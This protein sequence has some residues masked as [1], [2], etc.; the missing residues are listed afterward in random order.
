VVQEVGISALGFHKAAMKTIPIEVIDYSNRN[1]LPL[2]EIPEELPYHTIYEKYNRLVNQRENERLTKMYKLNEKLM[3][4]VLLEKDLNSIVKVIGE[5]INTMVC[6][7]DPY[8]DLIGY[9]KKQDQSRCEI[10]HSIDL[11]IHQHKEMY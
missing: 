11:I 6:V 1:F 2:F 9:W 3:E 5:N 7:L 8:F 10:K 4:I